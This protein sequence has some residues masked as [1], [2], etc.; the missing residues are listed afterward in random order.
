MVFAYPPPCLYS[1]FSDILAWVNVADRSLTPPTSRV[2]S[3]GE[4]AHS[5]FSSTGGQAVDARTG[6]VN[7]RIRLAI[8]AA[9]CVVA[10]VAFPAFAHA[11]AWASES[12]VG[13]IRTQPSVVAVDV[14]GA[15]ALNARSAAMTVGGVSQK[16][17]VT[18]GAASG[19]WSSTESLVGGAWRVIWSWVADTGGASKA[20]VYCYPTG[21]SGGAKAVTVTIKDAHGITLNHS[22]SFTLSGGP[23]FGTP[24]P[25]AGSKVKVPSPTISVPVADS[26]GVTSASATVNGIPATATLGGGKVTVTGFT[27]SEDGPVTVAVT[28]TNAAAGSSTRTWTFTMYHFANQTCHDPACHGTVY[29][30]DVAM[31][32]DCI[33]CHPNATHGTA[34]V[35]TPAPAAISISGVSFG[36]HT[37][38]ECHAPMNLVGLH[39]NTCATCHPA[40]KDTVAGTWAKGC[41]QGGCHTLASTAPMHATIDANHAIPADKAAC[42]AS[43]CHDAGAITPFA[44]KSVAEIHSNA[45]TV[46]AGGAT[47]TSCQIC[48][49]AGVTPTA[50]C[51]S[52]GCHPDRASAHGYDAA[53]HTGTPTAS[54]YTISGV[55]YPSLVCSGCHSVELGVEH[56]KTT[57]S[58]NTGCAECHATLVGQ[59]TPSW[60]KTKCAQA[61]CHTAASTAPLHATITADHAR[62]TSASDNACFASGCH[63]DG[64]LAAIHANATHVTAQGT[65]AS[66]M[67]CHASGLPTTK[68][69]IVCHADKVASHYVV[70]TH[71]ATV[72]SANMTI[73]G[74]SV[75]SHNCSE[76]H[77]SAE[78]GALHAGGCATC[79]PTPAASVKPWNKQCATAGCHTS[80]PSAQH[81]QIDSGHTRPANAQADTCFA[82]G[83]HTGGVNLAAIHTKGGC[84]TCH[85]AGKTLT[86]NCTASGCHANLDGHGDITA[87]HVS[88]GG[89]KWLDLGLEDDDHW[90]GDAPFGLDVDCSMCHDASLVTLHESDCFLCHGSTDS[91]VVNAIRDHATGCTNCH[92]DAHASVSHQ[93]VHDGGA[94]DCHG[95]GAT[96]Y[97]NNASTDNCGA[98]HTLAGVVDGTPPVTTSDIIASYFGPATIHLSAADEPAMGGSHVAHTY[99]RLDGAAQVEGAQID[100]PAPA[101]GS[102][103]HSI[104]FWS[105]D[106]A[107]NV[108]SPHITQGFTITPRRDCAD[109]DSAV[110]L[111]FTGCD[112]RTDAL[113]RPPAGRLSFL[114]LLLHLDQQ[115]AVLSAD[116]H[117]ITADGVNALD[118]PQ[119]DGQRDRPR[120]SDHLLQARRRCPGCVDRGPRAPSREWECRAH[121]E[122]LVC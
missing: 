113:D 85:A 39:A 44:G 59:L 72:T 42:L 31:G 32:P 88:S 65:V 93:A 121:G 75:G 81:A 109:H 106:G 105:V 8:I 79:H 66:C 46:T 23:T 43:G 87:A 104:E 29:D 71:T 35:G 67:V 60:D 63:T 82:V 54:T 101:N 114:E 77:A 7:G 53:M 38:A 78:L 30:A 76:C 62:L 70:A 19:H 10:V 36:T 48:H 58:G 41:V 74:T 102:Q 11:A 96:S 15:S 99:Y 28:A 40:P 108:E 4:I 117:A 69:C 119:R 50:N 2:E 20:T 22:W 49:A 37:C 16:T 5:M 110:V 17:F 122:V 120:G 95:L 92:T 56:T 47:R 27:L 6:F 51:T 33:S 107:G 73:L 3:L 97:E 1:Y 14:F 83:C 9:L 115:C 94:C 90:E 12:P 13:T 24:L 61:G 98:C 26:V 103:A 91:N 118:Q 112:S 34:H 116:G 111:Q 21:L 84:V 89:S 52:A 55:T 80:G 100:V 18:Q 68:D 25:A 64:N 45:S 86:T 57:S